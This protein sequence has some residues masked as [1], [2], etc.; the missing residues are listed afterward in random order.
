M[1]S[2]REA[3]ERISELDFTQRAYETFYDA[4]DDPYFRDQDP[5]VIFDALKDKVQI[6]SFGDHLKRYIYEKII[7]FGNLPNRTNKKVEHGI[8]NIDKI[9]SIT[10]VAMSNGSTIP[11]PI[12]AIISS[13]SCEMGA[14]DTVVGVTTGEDRSEYYAYITIQYTKTEEV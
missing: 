10:G 6:I 13:W 8:E 4:V 3:E 11:M 14:N 12:M 2:D 1:T 7:D 5:Q 9:I